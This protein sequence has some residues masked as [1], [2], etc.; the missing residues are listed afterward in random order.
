[1]HFFVYFLVLLHFEKEEKAG[2]FAFIV[3]RMPCYC[4]R[5]VTPPYGAMG[6]SAVR[7]FGIS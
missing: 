5:S 6:R 4:K 3:L 1:M 7:D 2:C